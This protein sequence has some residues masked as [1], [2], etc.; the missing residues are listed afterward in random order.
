MAA[1]GRAAEARKSLANVLA[2]A[3][4][5]GFVGLQFEAR[6]ALGEIEMK[7]GETVAGRAHLKQLQ[8]E[9]TA[10]GFTLIARK[11]VTPANGTPH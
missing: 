5:H 9:A 7:S 4:K 6:L 11:A 10:K 2:E 1:L 3:M 8:K